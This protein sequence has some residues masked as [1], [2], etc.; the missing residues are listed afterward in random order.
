MAKLRLLLGK[1]L[2]KVLTS[3]EMARAKKRAAKMMER[4]KLAL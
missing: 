3:G 4:P 2:A 1:T